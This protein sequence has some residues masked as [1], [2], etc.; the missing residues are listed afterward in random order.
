MS[1]NTKVTN[2]QLEVKENSARN[3]KVTNIKLEVKKAVHIT[4]K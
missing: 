2:I 3:T 4:L 1:V